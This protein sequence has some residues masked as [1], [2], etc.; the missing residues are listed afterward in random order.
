MT[1]VLSVPVGAVRSPHGAATTVLLHLAPGA[2]GLLAFVGLLPLAGALGLPSVA[3]LAGV[4]LFVVPAVQLGILEVHRRRRPFDPAVALGVRLPLPRVL[5]WAVLEIVLAGA[6]FMLTAPLTRLIQTRLFG[7]WP[8]AWTIRLRTDGL[9]SDEALLITAALLLL[10]TVLVAPVVEELYFRGFLLPRMP[11]RL[12]AWRV[13]A[14]VALFA[15][16][17]LYSPWLTP[18]RVIAILPLAYVA[19]RTQDVR[20]GMVAHV[21]LN[22]T[23][24]AA[25]LLFTGTR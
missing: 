1:A 24:L 10:G 16:Y 23:D 12:G 14:H 2:V 13:P 9:Y 22:A 20:I 21:V 6:M 15:G 11:Q 5:G 3:A 19:L 7:W 4:G 17:H 8:D 25:I 18:T